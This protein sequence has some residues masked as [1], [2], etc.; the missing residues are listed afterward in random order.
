MET[1]GLARVRATCDDAFSVPSGGFVAASL[2][3]ICCTAPPGG[4][5]VVVVQA[6]ERDRSCHVVRFPNAVAH[7]ALD[8]DLMRLSP[9]G[10]DQ[11]VADRSGE[12]EV[13]HAIA[14]DVTDLR[15]PSMYAVLLKRP[16]SLV[17]P[18][19]VTSSRSTA[20]RSSSFIIVLQLRWASLT[21]MPPDAATFHS[22]LL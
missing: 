22:S 14:V 9:A 12:S 19:Q 16:R 8:S 1:R 13:A 10:R 5:G 2:L 15:R 6:K 11:L 3:S 4:P 17:M 20:A 18:D 21:G 7:G